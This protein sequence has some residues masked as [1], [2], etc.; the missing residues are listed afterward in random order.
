MTRSM[1]RRFRRILLAST[2][3]VFGF[4]GGLG[5]GSGSAWGQEAQGV[6]QAKEK[7]EGAT[8]WSDPRLSKVELPPGTEFVLRSPKSSDDQSVWVFATVDDS[9]KTS[10]LARKFVEDYSKIGNARWATARI[11]G[12]IAVDKI[13]IC[14]VG[15]RGTIVNTIARM[16]AH[17]DGTPGEIAYNVKIEDKT[18]VATSIIL[19]TVV[20]LPA[21]AQKFP[22]GTE[23]T[24]LGGVGD[25]EGSSGS[26]RFRIFSTGSSGSDRFAVLGVRAI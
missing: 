21:P 4:P 8:V 17:E 1:K 15:T 16:G 18:W 24:L 13:H 11:D 25:K 6:V 26:D 9:I 12:M 10:E 3:A 5:W 22:V 20:P 14:K 19:Q 23:V 2:L 7:A